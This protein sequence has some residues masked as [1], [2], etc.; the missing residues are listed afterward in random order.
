MSVRLSPRQKEIVQALADGTTQAVVAQQM[1]ISLQTVKNHLTAARKSNHAT[2]TMALVTAYLQPNG[3][4][5]DLLDLTQRVAA[6]EALHG[7]HRHG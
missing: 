5:P 6:L 7:T 2:T 4:K 3:T 1:G